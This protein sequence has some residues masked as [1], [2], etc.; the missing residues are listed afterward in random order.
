MSA[1]I[2]SVVE[3]SSRKLFQISTPP[4][5]YWL[6]SDVLRKGPDDAMLQQT[7]KECEAYPPRLRLLRTLREDGTWPISGQR[8]LEEER[9]PGPPI[10]WTYI[11]ILRNLYTLGD[12]VTSKEDGNVR[13]ALERLLSWQADDG[14]I[15]GPTTTAFP[16]PHYNGFALRNLNQFNMDLDPRTYRLE[17]WLVKMQRPDGGWNIP[18]IQDL[19]YL[20]KYKHMR[21]RDFMKLI[22]GDH[23]PPY[24]PKEHEHIPSCV[25]STLTVLRG[26]YWSPS[27]RYRREMRRGADFVL[28]RFFKRNYHPSFYQSEKNWTTLKYPTHFGS[29]LSALEVLASMRY[30]P[31]DERMEEAIGWLLKARSKDGFWYR[32]DRPNPEKDQWITE[33]ALSILARYAGMYGH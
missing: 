12:Y 20:P 6:L 25:W 19:R 16:E 29:G 22:D 2:R 3:E 4:V 30:G 17:Q 14:H 13:A 33:I 1:D 18:Y 23:M 8:K 9:G 24:D 21:M 28:D 11:T 5:R 10:G 31:E 32:S 27:M 26:F 7:V 15:P